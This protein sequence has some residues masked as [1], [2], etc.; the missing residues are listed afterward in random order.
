MVSLTNFFH[1]ILHVS[2]DYSLNS[3]VKLKKRKMMN[4]T[5]QHTVNRVFEFLLLKVAPFVG[6]IS[7]AWPP[8]LE[9]TTCSPNHSAWKQS[10]DPGI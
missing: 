1:V 10:I 9:R 5:S 3:M 4:K 2:V 6:P 7:A 8:R